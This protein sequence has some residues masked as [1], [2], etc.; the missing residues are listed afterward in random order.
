MS[1]NAFILYACLSSPPQ[2]NH[3]IILQH[4]QH[5]LHDRKH[6]EGKKLLSDASFRAPLLCRSDGSSQSNFPTISLI[7][8]AC[9]EREAGGTVAP[10]PSPQQT[11]RRKTDSIELCLKTPFTVCWH[12][13]VT[14]ERSDNPLVRVLTT[15]WK[16]V[17]VGIPD[18][19]APPIH[20]NPPYVRPVC[21]TLAVTPA[22]TTSG[23]ATW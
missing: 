11:H 21:R 7:K 16:L 18:V 23:S 17:P 1:I 8:A 14:A 19:A 12:F 20:A 9:R 6:R 2:T 4:P 15:V 13:T 22:P 10:P 5:H 3:L